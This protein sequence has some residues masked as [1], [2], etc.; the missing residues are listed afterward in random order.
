LGVDFEPRSFEGQGDLIDQ[1]IE[2]FELLDRNRPSAVITGEADR[3]ENGRIRP[4]RIEN[5][6]RYID[7]L[8]STP[9]WL[10]GL[11]GPR[12]R[13][14]VA[15]RQTCVTGSSGDHL[16]LGLAGHHHTVAVEQ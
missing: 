14:D 7:R 15:G 5:P 1:A 11:D 4:N 2:Q 10:A 16:G 12:G 3:A 6:F 13:G 9:R 8:H